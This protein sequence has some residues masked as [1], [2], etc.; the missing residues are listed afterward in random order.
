MIGVGRVAHAEEEPQRD[1]RKEIRQAGS[2]S[3]ENGSG[4]T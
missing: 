4:Q 2:I 1:H 3:R